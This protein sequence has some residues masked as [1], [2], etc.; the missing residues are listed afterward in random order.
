MAWRDHKCR[1]KSKHY[2]PDSRNKA[3]V[4]S[5]RTRGCIPEDWDVLVE[6][7][8]FE[9]A[10]VYILLHMLHEDRIFTFVLVK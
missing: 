2:I 8:Y 10:V 3:L 1:L 7:W 4:K 9:E 6:N 5:N